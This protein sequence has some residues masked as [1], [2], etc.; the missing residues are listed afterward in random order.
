MIAASLCRP[1]ADGPL[2]RSTFDAGNVTEGANSM[3]LTD[4]TS[5]IDEIKEHHPN[6]NWV[7]LD[8]PRANGVEGGWQGHIPSGDGPAEVPAMQTELQLASECE[9]VIF[10]RSGFVNILLRKMEQKVHKTYRFKRG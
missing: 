7:Y 9:K 5:T 3:L 8:R 2:S 4:D 10:G 6:Y 1:I